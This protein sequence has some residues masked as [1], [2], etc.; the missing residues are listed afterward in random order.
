MPLCFKND[1]IFVALRLVDFISSSN[2]AG[3]T[4]L[5]SDNSSSFSLARFFLNFSFN[6]SR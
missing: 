5:K 6:S 3:I 2:P 4:S 1:F